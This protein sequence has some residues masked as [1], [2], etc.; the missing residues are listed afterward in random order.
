MMG[1][2]ALKNHTA[3]DRPLQSAGHDVKGQ[4]VIESKYLLVQENILNVSCQLN[5]N[6][7]EGG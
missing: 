1:S 6:N 3:Q 7:E 5:D 4:A 2:L